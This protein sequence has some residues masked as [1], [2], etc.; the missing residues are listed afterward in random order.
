M[1]G[2]I[3]VA[4]GFA[5]GCTLG[6]AEK[7]RS[8]FL[9]LRHLGE[10]AYSPREFV[11]NLAQQRQRFLIWAPDS[12]SAGARSLFSERPISLRSSG[13]RTFST[14]L[15]ITAFRVTYK[16]QRKDVLRLLSDRREHPIPI[17][18]PSTQVAFW[19]SI[20]STNGLAQYGIAMWKPWL[21]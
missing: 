2:R 19:M 10:V 8:Q 4:I 21:D 16:S 15:E 6:K 18:M 5:R 3:N 1:E 17:T 11:G 13:L 9:S 12:Y 20:K 14:V 7:V